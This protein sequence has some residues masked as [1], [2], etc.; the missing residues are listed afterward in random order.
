MAK[1]SSG[2]QPPKWLSTHPSHEDRINDLREYSAKVMPLYHR[3]EGRR[4]RRQIT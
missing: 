3:R 2:G 1:V 4:S